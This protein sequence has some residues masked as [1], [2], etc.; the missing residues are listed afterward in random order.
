MRRSRN[1]GIA[2]DVPL[3][4][5]LMAQ[6]LFA[7]SATPANSYDASSIEVLEGLEPVR[8]RPGMYVGGTDERA[9]H[10]LAAEVLD[11]PVNRRRLAETLERLAT[12]RETLEMPTRYAEERGAARQRQTY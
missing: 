3:W 2:C 7:S 1:T 10:H 9:L 4:F 11:K 12:L 5:R 8:R 6:D